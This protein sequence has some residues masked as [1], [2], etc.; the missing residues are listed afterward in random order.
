MYTENIYFLM[1]STEYVAYVRKS[2]H[3]K[4]KLEDL[5][6]YVK[7]RV[8]CRRLILFKN[9]EEL[10]IT[11]EEGGKYENYKHC[12][13]ITFEYATPYSKL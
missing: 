10:K 7:V 9:F 2:C 11:L 4:F 8:K 5:S 13:I 1:K 6:R 3:D 12:L